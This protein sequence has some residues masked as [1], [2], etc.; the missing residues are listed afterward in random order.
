KSGWTAPVARTLDRRGD[1]KGGPGR[2][3]PRRGTDLLRIGA[4]G[5]A[6]RARSRL[7]Q[8]G[9]SVGRANLSSHRHGR[10]RTRIHRRARVARAS[11][12]LGSGGLTDWLPHAYP[13][14]KSFHIISLVASMA[15][16]PSLPPPH[17]CPS[18]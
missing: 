10:R 18:A 13:W 2:G 5:N 17:V 9:R 16:L 7:S 3:T 4:F 1:Q 11:R 15:G 8:S 14:I 12:P 6:R